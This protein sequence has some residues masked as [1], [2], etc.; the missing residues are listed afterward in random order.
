MEPVPRQPRPTN[1]ES[2]GV[3]FLENVRRPSTGSRLKSAKTFQVS[4]ASIADS[5]VADTPKTRESA[6]GIDDGVMHDSQIFGSSR[7]E[8]ERFRNPGLL[9]ERELFLLIGNVSD[10]S[11][12]PKK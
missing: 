10:G 11:H 12:F 9:I 7:M 5:L 3:K 4:A 1:G 6:E 2:H 8:G